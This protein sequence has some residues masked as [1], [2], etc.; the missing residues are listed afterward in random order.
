VHVTRLEVEEEPL[1]LCNLCPAGQGDDHGLDAFAGMLHNV[2]GNRLRLQRIGEALQAVT[3]G[4]A[5]AAVLEDL[6]TIDAV[7]ESICDRLSG[8]WGEQDSRL[9]AV[10]VMQAALDCWGEVTGLG[11]GELAIQSGLWNVYMERDGY[12][13]TQ[14]MDKYLSP[15]TLPHRPRWRSIVATAEYVL[16]VCPAS[17]RRRDELRR[18]LER[19]RQSGC[20]ARP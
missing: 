7:L 13:R 10:Q 20:G 11:K 14:T 5:Q 12:L 15:G 18:I 6:S 4:E 2:E 9:L 1:L 8:N 17:H 3:A 19:L 16:S